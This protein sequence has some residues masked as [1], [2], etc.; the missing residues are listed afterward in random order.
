[1]RAR[2]K[3]F[4]TFVASGDFRRFFVSSLFVTYVRLFLTL[5][6]RDSIRVLNPPTL[7]PTV[8]SAE[9]QLM[10]PPQKKSKK[11]TPTEA[12]QG[13]HQIAEDNGNSLTAEPLQISDHERIAKLEAL[14]KAQAEKTVHIFEAFAEQEAGDKDDEAID[15]ELE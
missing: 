15:R 2:V 14:Q 5:V 10:M 4:T 9:K 6:L 11:N 1:M 8:V 3:R 7:A 13:D 12:D